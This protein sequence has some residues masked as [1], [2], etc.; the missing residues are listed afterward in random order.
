LSKSHLAATT[1]EAEELVELA[2]RRGAILQWATSSGSTPCRGSRE[3]PAESALLE[4]LRIAPNPPPRIG[5]LPDAARKSA[6][7]WT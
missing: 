5:L 2:Q 6:S 1:Q 4:A 7:S 3:P